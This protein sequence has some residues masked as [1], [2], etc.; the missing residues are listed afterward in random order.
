VIKPARLSASA[1]E[2]ALRR[3]AVAA[4]VAKA[5]GDMATARTLVE[6]IRKQAPD[7]EWLEDLQNMIGT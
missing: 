2:P 4:R 7:A 5:S 3:W 6:A 1:P